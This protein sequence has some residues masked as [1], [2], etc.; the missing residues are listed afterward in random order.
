MEQIRTDTNTGLAR[1][2]VLVESPGVS[3]P[4]FVEALIDPRAVFRDPS[5]VADHPWF[6]DAE[7][8]TILLSWARDEL[9]VEQVAQKVLPDLE[10]GSHIDAVVEALSRFDPVAAGEYLSAVATI[11]GRGSR[12]RSR[13][14]TH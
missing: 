10:R 9:V 11:R 4:S 13:R 5:E 12:R 14:L 8:R 2:E 7:K 6:T 3:E 1:P